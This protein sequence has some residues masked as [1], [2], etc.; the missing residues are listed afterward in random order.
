[1]P[2]SPHET[3]VSLILRLQ[4]AEDVAAWEEFVELYTPVVHRAATARGLQEADA[5]NIVQ[6]V[7]LAVARSV[8]RSNGGLSVLIEVVFDRGC[9]RSL[10]TKR[11]ECSKLVPLAA[12][13]R[14]GLPPNS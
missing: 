4:D 1:M 7:L 12:W 10:G 14:M 11:S 6:E 3:R 8:E 2:V 9:W 5:D 13:E